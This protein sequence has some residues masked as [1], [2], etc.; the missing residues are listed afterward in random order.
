MYSLE[1]IAALRQRC[2]ALNLEGSQ[3]LNKYTDEELQVICNGIG[4]E[5]FPYGIRS[6]TSTLHPT[7]E[8][9]AMVHD[10]EFEESDGLKSSFTDA[11]DRYYTNGVI[12]AKAEYGWYNPARYIVMAQALRHSRLCQLFGWHGYKEMHERNR[13]D[14]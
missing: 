12:A 1:E 3:K 14:G 9:V 7:L 11:N 5:A 8:P 13:G 10:V 2:K 6:V 4:P